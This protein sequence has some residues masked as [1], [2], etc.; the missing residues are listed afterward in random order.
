MDVSISEYRITSLS[1]EKYFG[2]FRARR[3]KAN[4]DRSN[5]HCQIHTTEYWYEGTGAIIGSELGAAK[6]VLETEKIDLRYDPNVMQQGSELERS[7][8]RVYDLDGI[9]GHDGLNVIDGINILKVNDLVLG[10]I[11]AKIDDSKDALPIIIP[12]RLSLGDLV[13]RGYCS[14]S[15]GDGQLRLKFD[16]SEA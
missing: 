14:L 15:N 3:Y 6:F 8:V 16:E 2:T 12:P 4:F 1:G 11:L 7:I 9:L 5:R 10:Q 13:S